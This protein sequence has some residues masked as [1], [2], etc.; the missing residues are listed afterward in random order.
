MLGLKVFTSEPAAV[1]LTELSVAG[2]LVGQ[3]GGMG[4]PS[5]GRRGRASPGSEKI[6]DVSGAVPEA[7]LRKRWRRS[8]DGRLGCVCVACLGVVS[9]CARWRTCTRAG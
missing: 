3:W 5:G 1:Q 2:W 6:V 8:S 4:G 7:M 9:W